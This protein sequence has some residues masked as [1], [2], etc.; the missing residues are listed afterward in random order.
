MSSWHT[1]PSIFN[2]GHKAVVELLNGPVNVEE[3]VDGSQFSFGKF[4]TGEIDES[5]PSWEGVKPYKTELRV[6]SKGAIIQPDAPPKMFARAVDAVIERRLLLHPGYTY[7]GEVL[8][9]PKHNVLAYGRVPKG[10]VILFDINDGEESY[11]SYEAKVAEAA[12][13][14]FEVVPLLHSGTLGFPD[15]TRIL[16]TTSCL[17]G[18][19]IEGVVVKPCGYNL[20]GLDKKVLFGKYVSEAFKEVAGVEWKKSNP[21]SADILDILAA[22]YTTRARWEK[23]IQHLCDAGQLSNSP[24]DIGP[25]VKEI[26]ADV[27]RECR[28]DI[29]EVLLEWALP[30]LRRG[31]VKGFPEYYKQQL[32]REAFDETD[33]SGVGVGSTDTPVGGQGD[34]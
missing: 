26:Q 28:D 15:L 9:R 27:L 2:L 7:R 10:N 31:V 3:K 8:D 5:A 18:P 1:Y 24:K 12:R 20:F 23:S 33:C 4:S 22:K 17:G 25:L 16:E 34:A 30:H 29:V 11:L 6:R 32:L 14:G 13:I 21:R 19:R